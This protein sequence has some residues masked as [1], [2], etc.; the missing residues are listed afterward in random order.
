MEKLGFLHNFPNIINEPVSEFTNFVFADGALHLFFPQERGTWS[1]DSHKHRALL[2]LLCKVDKDAQFGVLVHLVLQ[3]S[4]HCYSL[5]GRLVSPTL[6]RGCKFS[7]KVVMKPISSYQC[8]WTLFSNCLHS[9]LLISPDPQQGHQPGVVSSIRDWME[10]F[11]FDFGE[12]FVA[13]SRKLKL[14]FT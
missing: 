6:R 4:G 8:M 2:Q 12:F 5:T 13:I 3:G 10:H 11:D 14:C 7:G 1:S 9:T